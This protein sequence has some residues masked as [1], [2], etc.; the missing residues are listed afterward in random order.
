MFFLKKKKTLPFFYCLNLQRCI[1][2]K[3]LLKLRV[4]LWL[5]RFKSV[6][7]EDKDGLPVTDFFFYDS[8]DRKVF[9]HWFSL[10]YFFHQ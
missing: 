8:K 9:F 1:V 2:L 7:M 4:I 6:Q 5:N 10:F 3:R